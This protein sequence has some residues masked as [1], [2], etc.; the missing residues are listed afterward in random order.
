MGRGASKSLDWKS[1]NIAFDEVINTLKVKEIR[2]FDFYVMV[3]NRYFKLS[4]HKMHTYNC[5]TSPVHRIRNCITSKQL[6]NRGW[7]TG[8]RKME[9]RTI[10]YLVKMD[11][12]EEIE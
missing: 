8:K 9:G 1:L 7:K 12:T 11:N 2:K 10:L 6:K 4:G 5:N 3:Y